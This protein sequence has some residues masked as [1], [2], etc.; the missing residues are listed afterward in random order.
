MIRTC[1]NH[2]SNVDILLIGEEDE[3][4][5]F[6]M[7]LHNQE[8]LFKTTDID[9]M[10]ERLDFHGLFGRATPKNLRGY[11]EA[12]FINA[13]MR[14]YGRAIPY[15]QYRKFMKLV[16]AANRETMTFSD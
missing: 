14:K 6:L 1:I 10:V 11:Y 15:M 7:F 4:R 3:I 12:F 5:L 8:G 13:E 16:N 9:T 2:S